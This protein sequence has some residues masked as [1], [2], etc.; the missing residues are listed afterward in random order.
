MQTSK[1]YASTNICILL[2]DCCGM[3]RHV[4]TRIAAL[5]TALALATECGGNEG[6][7]QNFFKR[8]DDLA[9]TGPR[10]G[11]ASQLNQILQLVKSSLSVTTKLP[12]PARSTGELQC[13]ALPLEVRQCLHETNLTLDDGA[14]L[15]W[16]FGNA[17]QVLRQLSARSGI[18]LQAIMGSAPER[19]QVAFRTAGL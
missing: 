5:T 6:F 18:N 7:F 9:Q 4:P 3:V 16:F 12:V 17:A 14:I 19:V 8:C 10:Q 11:A 15:R 1:K 13:S 2:L